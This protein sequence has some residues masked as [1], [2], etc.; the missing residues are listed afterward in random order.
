M[1]FT[2]SL[3]ASE[4]NTNLTEALEEATTIA[5]KTKLNADYVPGTVTVISGEKLKSLGIN[6]LAEQNAFDMIVG[7]DSSTLS[8]RGAG[9]IYGSQGN[10]IK[11]MINDKPISSEIWGLP[12][13]GV[14]QIVFPIPT[15]AIDRIE[16]IRGPGSAIY[17]GNA[18][19]GVVNIVTKKGSNALFTTLS[20][21]ESDNFGRA[22]G[23]Y[24]SFEHNGL[25]VSTI[26]SAE[27]NDGWDMSAES[28]SLHQSGNLP[29]ASGNTLFMGDF[30]YKN[31]DFWAYHLEPKND[32]ARLQWD[33]T[34]YIPTDNH[35]TV[36]SNTYTLIGL[37]TEFNPSSNVLITLK[38]GL[39]QYTN[40]AYLMYYP[41]SV[42]VNNNPNHLDGMRT[43]DYVESTK[44]A[45]GT[46]TA[47]LDNHRI[48][49]GV[50]VSYLSVDQDNVTQTYT[51][52]TTY[53]PGRFMTLLSVK[54]PT[55]NNKALYL[56]DEIELDEKST[57][58]L[59]GRYDTYS[60]DRSAFS[61]RI[62]FVYLYD[63]SNIFKTQY[64]R[65][66]R[67][68][69]LAEQYSPNNGST[70]QTFNSET[71]DTYE[72]SYIFKTQDTSVKTTAFH[73]I[74]FDMITYHDF[75]YKTINF[76]NPTTVNGLELELNKNFESFN[77]GANIACYKS[78]KGEVR[79]PFTLYNPSE[80]ALSANTLVNVFATFN[81]DTSY[82]T[83]LWYHY[84]GGKHRVNNDYLLASSGAVIHS[85]S[86]YYTTN[87][88]VPVQDYLN[89]T[90]K[91]GGI[92]K[93]LD[94]EFG[95]KNVFG[96]TLRTLYYPLNQP[97]NTDIP[98]MGQTFWINLLYKF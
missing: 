5:T 76:D 20:R 71:A 44:Y 70:L 83:T 86:I 47:T 67:P 19:Y 56:Q 95:V 32:Y 97:N 81:S 51:N 90:Q 39:N 30:S 33:P 73:T 59:G 69:S 3:Y 82:P 36:Q 24:G 54:N 38:G 84:T 61:P 27:K 68:P 31:F 89:I 45:E 96:K 46:A 60:D 8:L 93:D 9:S 64:S 66:F 63:D 48:L 6:N 79:Q 18:I 78:H 80:F 77:L 74:T 62:G 52:S 29:S 10:K 94:L 85:G 4:D 26:L 34:N 37:K 87:G 13:L 14:G 49:G 16:I 57:L 35:N 12:K 22:I 28:Q 92:A 50:Y 11:W 75:T 41:S 91:I 88:S 58:T 2:Q 21:M 17:G 7:F 65:A 15:D 23:A 72:L 25:E 1:L 40:Q 53:D 42:L 98:Y 55:R 43:I